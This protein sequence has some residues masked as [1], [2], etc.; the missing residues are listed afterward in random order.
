MVVEEGL[1]KATMEITSVEV[2]MP[3]Y[4]L[5]LHY[6]HYLVPQNDCLLSIGAREKHKDWKAH[7]RVDRAS[8]G[9]QGPVHWYRQQRGT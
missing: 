8:A 3:G 2:S 7:S 1:E 9:I 6:T 5:V 4:R